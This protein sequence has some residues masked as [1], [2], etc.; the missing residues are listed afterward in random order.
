MTRENTHVGVDVCLKC[1]PRY[2][3]YVEQYTLA[4]AQVYATPAALDH[5]DDAFHRML[6][7][8]ISPE[9]STLKI[10]NPMPLNLV[11]QASSRHFG[12]HCNLQYVLQAPRICL[13]IQ[14]PS[15]DTQCSSVFAAEAVPCSLR[16]SS[17]AR[18]G[19]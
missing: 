12:T 17:S 19:R 3:T 6:Y 5:R 9:V 15:S 11:T 1:S 10:V 18:L 8:F 4:L 14:S 16:A 13:S 7:V 2:S